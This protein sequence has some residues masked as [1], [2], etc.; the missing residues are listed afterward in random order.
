MNI[1]TRESSEDIEFLDT[2]TIQ[3]ISGNRF[4]KIYA[5]GLNQLPIQISVKAAKKDGTI[6]RLTPEE[7]IDALSLCFTENDEKLKKDETNAGWCSTIHKNDYSVEIQGTSNNEIKPSADDGTFTLVMYIYTNIVESRRISVCVDINAKHFTTADPPKGAETMA[8]TVQ[9]IQAIDYSDKRNT[10]IVCG[11]FKG[12]SSNLG[13]ESRLT[14]EGPYKG[15]TDG[16]CRRRIVEIRPKNGPKFK[17]HEIWFEDITNHDVNGD[18]DI[19]WIYSDRTT[20]E[21]CFNILKPLS[22]PC[23]VIGKE[24]SQYS[25]HSINVWFK[26]QPRIDI[27]GHAIMVD[28]NYYYRFCPFVSDSNRTDDTVPMLLLYKFE[29]PADS[30]KW[31]WNDVTRT[32]FVHVFDIFGNEGTI[33]LI[34]DSSEHFDIPGRL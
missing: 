4:P 21:P 26:C 6:V 30:W 23:A 7:W 34:F 24:F 2:L 27:D 17:K 19:A 25:N 28:N 33:Q 9:A 11:D 10:D 13:W 3:T 8:I 29:M 31:K 16:T 1:I 15:H 22:S 5:N 20:K 12:M 14:T 32:T 18:A